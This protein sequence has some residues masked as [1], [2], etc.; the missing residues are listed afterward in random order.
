MSRYTI[1]QYGIPCGGEI[2][3]D[4][5]EGSEIIGVGNFKEKPCIYIVICDSEIHYEKLTVIVIQ[6]GQ[7]FKSE[8]Y[9]YIGT[10]DQSSERTPH[11][12]FFVFVIYD[13]VEG[14]LNAF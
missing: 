2:T 13:A 1:R 11:A 3:I 14:V 7:H 8:N 5:P 4:V 10:F 6:A 9:A 12:P